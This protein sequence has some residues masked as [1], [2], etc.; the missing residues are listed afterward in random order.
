MGKELGSTRGEVLNHHGFGT[1]F[2]VQTGHWAGSFMDLEARACLLPHI[3]A[4]PPKNAAA[5]MCVLT[6]SRT[7]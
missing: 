6:S 5:P 3:S 7:V 2:L 4:V 1:S